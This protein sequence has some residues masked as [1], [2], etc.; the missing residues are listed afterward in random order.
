MA[1]G[2]PVWRA[3]GGQASG[4]GSPK[5][6]LDSGLGLGAW[7]ARSA[8]TEAGSPRGLS[9][10]RASDGCMAVG[11]WPGGGGTAEGSGVL[12]GH[13]GFCGSEGAAQLQRARFPPGW[14]ADSWGVAQGST[15]WRA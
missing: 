6:N 15:I 7:Q 13:A 5:F 10:G 8:S 14:W 1:K 9:G 3:W 11:L 12:R 4:D 2:S